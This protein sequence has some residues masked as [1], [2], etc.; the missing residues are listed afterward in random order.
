MKYFASIRS[1]FSEMLA[2]FLDHEVSRMSAALS[3]YA[4]FSLSPLL[5]ILVGIVGIVFGTTEAERVVLSEASAFLGREGEET[6]RSMMASNDSASKRR[7]LRSSWICFVAC[8]GGE[9]LQG[10]Q[11]QSESYL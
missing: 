11:K 9:C 4:V 8:W 2:R 6:L 7:G 10:T 3:Y 1:F 5:I